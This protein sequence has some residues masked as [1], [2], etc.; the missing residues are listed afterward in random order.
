MLS[1]SDKDKLKFIGLDP[2]ALEN[3]IKAEA[4]TAI[5][6]PTGTLLSEEQL[7]QRDLVKIEEGKRAGVEEGKNAGFEIAH[8]TLIDK[9]GLKDVK[10][11][12]ETNKL[13]DALSLTLTAGD[14]GLKKQVTDLLRD[15]ETLLQEK[16]TVLKE[17]KQIEQKTQLLTFLPKNRNSI[18][19]DDEYLSLLQSNIKE[20][21]GVQIVELNGEVLKDQKTRANLPLKDAIEKVFE[22]RKWVEVQQQGQGRGEGD[23]TPTG[24]GFRKY[25]EFEKNYIATHGEDSNMGV[26][27]QKALNEAAAS[28]DFDFNS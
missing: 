12:D 22:A 23:Q 1:Q 16:E 18:L 27:F 15:K 2:I 25:S 11:T 3:A 17:K 26:E 10:K 7:T 19:S 21:D 4:E 24:K 6:I 20:V 5:A 14:E 28:P 13:A 9:F 8:K